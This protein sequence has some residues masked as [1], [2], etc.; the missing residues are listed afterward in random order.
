MDKPEKRPYVWEDDVELSA[1]AYGGKQV[2]GYT[3]DKSLSTPDRTAYVDSEGNLVM[4]FR[5]T[6][7]K[8]K[9]NT[10]RDLGTDAL[11]GLGL[12]KLSSR[13]KNQQKGLDSAIEKYGKDKVRT[14]GH[15]LGGALATTVGARRGVKSSS[16]NQ[17]V[18][19]GDVVRN[20]TYTNAT[21]YR[22]KNDPVSLLA[23][24][25]RGLKTTI[26]R[27]NGHNL[28]GNFI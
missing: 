9:N 5:G 7:L 12:Q 8:N 22:T 14:T 27:G 11:V 18:G 21:A 1:G 28:R 10:W 23:S 24:K 20:R 6:D 26:V 25:V 19:I 3:I 4:A 15:S 17:A 16:F 2:K 13:Y